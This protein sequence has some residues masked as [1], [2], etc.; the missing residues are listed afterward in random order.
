MQ[1]YPVQITKKDVK[2]LQPGVR[3]EY[4]AR[5]PMDFLMELSL[6]RIPAFDR[7]S[8]LPPPVIG[9]VDP[10]DFQ[11]GIPVDHRTRVRA[12]MRPSRAVIRAQIERTLKESTGVFIRIK[13]G[14]FTRINRTS[15][16]NS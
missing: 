14:Q 9:T 3:L 6:M 10:K 1:Y 5:T 4:E 12:P 8:F 13:D 2:G 7:L 15:P 16:S 11:L